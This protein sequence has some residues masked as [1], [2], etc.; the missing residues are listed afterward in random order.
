MV[1]EVE[2]E[3]LTKMAAAIRDH[4][5]LRLL[6]RSHDGT[7]SRRSVEPHHVVASGTRWYLLAFDVDR[8]DWR[9]G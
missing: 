3:V 4:R 5:Q 7:E 6:Y 1:P 8:N 2:V 9:Q